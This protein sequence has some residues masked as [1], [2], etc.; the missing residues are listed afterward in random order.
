MASLGL[1]NPGRPERLGVTAHAVK[2]QLA[3]TRRV[4]SDS[5]APAVALEAARG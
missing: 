4:R 5:A 1:A 2:L 3:A